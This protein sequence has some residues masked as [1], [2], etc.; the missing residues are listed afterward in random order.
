MSVQNITVTAQTAA[1][2]SFARVAAAADD[3]IIFSISVDGICQVLKRSAAA[4]GGASEIAITPGTGYV[5]LLTAIETGALPATGGTHEMKKI[6]GSEAQLFT[7]TVTVEG[8]S[9]I[10]A[11]T[12]N[13]TVENIAHRRFTANAAYGISVPVGSVFTGITIR[14]NSANE[15]SLSV[16]FADGDVDLLDA[17]V[18]T[19]SSTRTIL[20]TEF[21][22]ASQIPNVEPLDVYLA[23]SNW[24]SAD[25]DA[26]LS[27]KK[28]VF[29]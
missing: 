4:G 17:E 28:I 27:Y 2:V 11:A 24:N 10:P 20:A 16:G 6:N 5:V 14:N 13:E 9:V 22:T 19:A 7:G 29:E 1:N 26:W 23:S 18:I 3:A 15:F 8:E 12:V 21:N 25:I